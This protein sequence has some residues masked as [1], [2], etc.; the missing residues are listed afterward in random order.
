M[1]AHALPV[2]KGDVRGRNAQRDVVQMHQSVD[3]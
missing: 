2:S 3:M 1:M